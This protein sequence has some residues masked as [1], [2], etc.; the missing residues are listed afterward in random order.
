VTY[1]PV[2]THIIPISVT[3]PVPK[4]VEDIIQLTEVWLHFCHL[5]S[6]AAEMS[7]DP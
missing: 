1:L 2:L 3:L 5:P 4:E 7:G 6:N